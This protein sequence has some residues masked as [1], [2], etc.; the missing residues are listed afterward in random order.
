[1]VMSRRMKYVGE[2]CF[3]A[4]ILLVWRERM[5]MRMGDERRESGLLI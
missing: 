5:R 1:M 3:S 4:T 2:G